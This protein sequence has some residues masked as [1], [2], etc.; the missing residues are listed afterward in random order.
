MLRV[1]GLG[2]KACMAEMLMRIIG[3]LVFQ[4]WFAKA[5]LG[6]RDSPSLS[7]LLTLCVMSAQH[8]KPETL[9]AKRDSKCFLRM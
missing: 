7:W 8:L 6:Y 5:P 2:F 3:F 1:R 4:T 9:E